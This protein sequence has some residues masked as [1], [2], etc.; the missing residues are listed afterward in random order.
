FGVEAG[1]AVGGVVEGRTRAEMPV[2][3]ESVLRRRSRRGGMERSGMWTEARAARMRWDSAW[4]EAGGGAVAAATGWGVGG[5]GR[6]AWLRRMGGGGQRPPTPL[7]GGGAMRRQ[8]RQEGRSAASSWRARSVMESAVPIRR[9]SERG[10]TGG[11]SAWGGGG[12]ESREG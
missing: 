11:L 4:R 8:P 6:A 2:P 1:D 12:G 9:V 10:S 3:P 5:E 7:E